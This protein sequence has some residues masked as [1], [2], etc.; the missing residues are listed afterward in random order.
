MVR[1]AGDSATPAGAP[2]V[3][4]A[5]RVGTAETQLERVQ[6]QI[7]DKEQ[8]RKELMG[9]F[10]HAT[11]ESQA[12]FYSKRADAVNAARAKLRDQ[13]TALLAQTAP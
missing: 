10:E 4:P 2:D 7:E 13:E 9:N 12:T 11:T 3:P 6:R 5:N 8:E 1:A